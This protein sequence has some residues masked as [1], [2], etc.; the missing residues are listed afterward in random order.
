M[1]LPMIYFGNASHETAVL[2]ADIRRVRAAQ[3]ARF[4]PRKVEEHL[5]DGKGN[6]VTRMV[7]IA[8][9]ALAPT[10]REL[11]AIARG[12]KHRG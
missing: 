8:P 9:D 11:H 5:T 7:T 6:A 2:R 1:S 10:D 12:G 3:P 4:K